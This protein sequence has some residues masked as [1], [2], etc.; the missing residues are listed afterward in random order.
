MAKTDLH[1]LIRVRKWDVE[2]KQRA[3]GALLRNE[4][5]LLEFSAALERELAEE[6][7]FVSQSDPGHRM[8]FE[9]YVQ[10]CRQR[11][12]EI[13]KA[14]AQLRQRIDAARD[15]LAE[16]FRR[17]K[18]F[19]ITQE[20]RDTAEAAEENRV[21]QLTLDEIGLELHRRRAAG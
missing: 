15:E 10:R 11:R 13:E 3:L 9:P 21:E 18:T 12:E 2:E 14:M 20:V 8:T 7:A 5:Q 4:E 6:K 16:A 17:L 19:E 1:T